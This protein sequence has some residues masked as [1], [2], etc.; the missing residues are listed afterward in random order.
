M[1]LR[2]IVNF[3]ASYPQLAQPASSLLPMAAQ[4]RLACRQLFVLG[5]AAILGAPMAS[6]AADAAEANLD[7]ELQILRQL[8]QQML[9]RID[10]LEKIQKAQAAKNGGPVLAAPA[11]PATPA[12]P[13]PP[14]APPP[15]AVAPSLK[16]TPKGFKIVGNTVFS[17]TDL[18]ALLAADIGK[19]VDF[20]GLTEV[21]DKI[22]VHY[23][24]NGY[25]LAVA[26][27]PKQ[28]IEDGMVTIEVLEGRIGKIDFVSPLPKTATITEAQFK[29][30][31]SQR[32]KEGDLITENSLE[33]PLLQLR[34]LP[35]VEVRSVINPGDTPGT[36][37]VTLEVLPQP[38]LRKLNGNVEFDNF[39]NRFAGEY[40]GTVKA[41]YMSPFGI[42]DTVNISAT[43]A[44]KPTNIFGRLGYLAPVGNWGTR[45]GANLSRLSYALGKDFAALEVNGSATLA[46]LVAVHPFLR[47]KE[48]NLIGQF[49]YERKRLLDKQLNVPNQEKDIDSLKF[50][51]NG[52]FRGN[53]HVNT[54]SIDLTFGHLKFRDAEQLR[55]DQSSSGFYTAGRF[56]KINF[57]A[58]RLQQFTPN[59]EAMFSITGQLASKNL[60]SAEKF[61]LGGANRV[62]G[63]PAGEAGG[64]QGFVSTAELRYGVPSVKWGN[65]TLALSTFIDY[66]MVMRNKDTAHAVLDS[67]SSNKRSLYSVGFGFKLGAPDEFLLRSD[68]AWGRS[69]AATSDTSSKSPR[70]WLQGLRWF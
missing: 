61:V 16:F 52:D 33:R 25:F 6:Y 41:N 49:G 45:V 31:L 54:A 32:L 37:N 10:A 60:T 44:E 26:M 17:E 11:L 68:I 9:Q 29:G 2:A 56:A 5:F 46:E 59:I 14:V 67:T 43:W 3:P 21:A 4:I 7:Q 20:D 62:R 15:V 57:S 51:F 70:F 22:K 27:L 28:E 30:M 35:G 19:E 23:R 18:K 24:N 66:G 42:G 34:D 40:R 58:N 64:D 47:T 63:Y 39:G 69:G 53:G 36:A 65:A 13:V 38:N 50:Q 1:K 12:L 8:A 48:Y 55:D